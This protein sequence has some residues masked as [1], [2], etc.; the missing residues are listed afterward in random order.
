[1]KKIYHLLLHILNNFA[2]IFAITFF[3]TLLIDATIFGQKTMV[4]SY[5][6]YKLLISFGAAVILSLFYQIN[7]TTMLIQLLVTFIVSLTVIYIQGFISGWFNFHD[8]A[9]YIISIS[10]NIIGLVGVGIYLYIR[11]KRQSD[12]LNKQLQNFKERD[13][14]EKN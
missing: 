5:V 4:F 1:M 13:F 14:N 7:R 10:C 3:A 9:F 12:M 2:I 11:R 8:L 6:Y